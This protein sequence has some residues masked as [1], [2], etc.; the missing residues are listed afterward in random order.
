[1]GRVATNPGVT[2]VP[3]TSLVGSDNMQVTGMATDSEAQFF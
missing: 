1:V 3:S 2:F